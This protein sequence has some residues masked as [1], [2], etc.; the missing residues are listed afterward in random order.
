[1]NTIQI[2]AM[3]VAGMVCLWVLAIFIIKTYVDH[4]SSPRTEKFVVKDR[5][6]RVPQSVNSETHDVLAYSLGYS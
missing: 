2:I 4:M 6:M 3:T 1:M 5:L